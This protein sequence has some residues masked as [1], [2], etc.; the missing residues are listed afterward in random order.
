MT[1]S[2]TSPVSS[3]VRSWWGWGWAEAQPDDA[4]CLALGALVPGTLA[5]PLP[6]PQ[7]TD[8]RIGPPTITPPPTLQQLVTAEPEQRAAPAV[9]K[10]Y[11]DVMRLLRGQLGRIPDLVARP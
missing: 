1:H 9:G 4:E 3:R 8:L 7:V 11:R 6:L 2:A 5:R 10:A